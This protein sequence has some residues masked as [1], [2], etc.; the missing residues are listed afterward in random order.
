MRK[1]V[2][3]VLDV[4]K[5][6]FSIIKLYEEIVIVDE[7]KNYIYGEILYFS[8][9]FFLLLWLLFCEER[10]LLVLNVFNKVDG[11]GGNDVQ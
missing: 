3:K 5:V 1:C 7:W 4:L 2:E 9:Q 11:V 10:L 6:G 8:F